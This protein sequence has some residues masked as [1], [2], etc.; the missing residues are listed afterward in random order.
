MLRIA[1][2]SYSGT[3]AWLALRLLEEGHKVNYFLSSKEYAPI[4][5]GIVPSPQLINLRDGYKAM[6]D[7][8]RYDLSI[9]DLTGRERW[10]EYSARLCP[11]I[12]DGKIHSK[13]EDDRAFAMEVMENCGILVPPYE[14]FEE[15]G[16]AKSYV[17]K[18]GKTYVYKCD[19]G[20]DVG[21]DTTYVS[22]GVEDMLD[23]IDKLWE[24]SKGAKFILQERISGTEVSTEGFFNGEDFYLLN[25]TLECKKFM[26]D[27]IGPQ[28]GCSGA[29]VFTHGLAEPALYKHGLGRMKSYLRS[30]GYVGPLDLNT[31]CTSQGAYGLEFT[32]RFGYDAIALLMEMYAG[33]FGTMLHRIAIGDIPEQSYRAEFCAS[34]RLSIPPYP[35]EHATRHSKGQIIEGIDKEDYEHTFMYD[36]SKCNGHMESCGICGF[37]ACPMGCGDSIT[38]AFSACN[39]RLQRIK[40]PGLQ[41]RTDCEK[42]IAKRYDELLRD[43]WLR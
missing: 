29:V 42:C 18:T 37:L 19:G 27:D 43:G 8:G 11:T 38:S 5:E 35:S 39:S 22:S 21:T 28:T 9:F 24:E 3:G 23:H 26:N 14:R 12:G 7:Y 13:L 36:I 41:Y 31:I 34:I 6:P 2:N 4:L 17:L 15:P 32:P 40:V 33:D 20:Q 25:S 16:A 1:L 10:A 30:I